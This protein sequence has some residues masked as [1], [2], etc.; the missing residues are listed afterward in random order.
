M[1]KLLIHAREAGIAMII[2]SLLTQIDKTKFKIF[3]DIDDDAKNIL[4]FEPEFDNKTEIDVIVYGIDSSKLKRTEN[5]LKKVEKI[6]VPK[7]ALVDTW[8]GLDRFWNEQNELRF[9]IEHVFVTDKCSLNDL[10]N[11]G[12]ESDKI[13]LV[14]NPVLETIKPLDVT[15]KINTKRKLGLHLNVPVLLFLSEPLNYKDIGDYISLFD[16]EIKNKLSVVD[17]IQSKYKNFQFAFRTHPVEKKIT[18]SGWTDLSSNVL[19]E[20]LQIS[21][22]VVGLSSTPM[23]YAVQLGLKVE[24]LAYSILNWS[25]EQN[26]ISDA[27]WK[28]LFEDGIIQNETLLKSQKSTNSIEAMSIEDMIERLL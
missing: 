9:Q 13:K 15:A 14:K 28:T 4:K 18:P 12:I 26:Q 2:K 24:S 17:Y 25:P 5:F 6:K 1:I 19:E 7:I 27:T 23:S 8:K 22:Y 10:I 16:V 11:N 3:F 21:D 20:V